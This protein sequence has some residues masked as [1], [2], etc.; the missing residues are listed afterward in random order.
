MLDYL[1]K[2]LHAM[3]VAVVYLHR[4]SYILDDVADSCYHQSIVTVDGQDI[5]RSSSRDQHL[6][7]S[8]AILWLCG[9]G[10]REGWW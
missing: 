2:V 1:S 5:N 9:E 8:L 7:P 6:G 10:E 4:S 3:E